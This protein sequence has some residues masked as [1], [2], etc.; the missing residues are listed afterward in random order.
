MFVAI[1]TAMPEE[2]L[3]SR[4]GNRDG[5]TVGSAARLVVVR[6][7]VDGVGVDLAKHLGG[8][9]RKPALRVP[10][11]GGG[12]AV[13]RAEV[14]LPVHERIAHREGLGEAHERVVDRR[15]AVRMVRAHHVADDAR[16][17]LVRTVGL[18]AGLVHPVEDA[19]VHRLQ[20]VA[21]VGQRATDDDVHRIAEEA[22]PHLLVELARLDAARPER[23]PWTRNYF[24]HPGT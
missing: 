10:H 24:R 1:P 13:E 12:V 6:L 7:E 18:H 5:S 21:D 14:P 11:R 2:P 9:P 17:L 19:A 22:R 23:A 16:R 3:T 20:P 8:K 15:V 4:F